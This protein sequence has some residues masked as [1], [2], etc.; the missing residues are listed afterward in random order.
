MK[1]QKTI[2][3]DPETARLAGSMPNFSR[4][5]RVALHARAMGDDIESERR[6]RRTWKRV[7]DHLLDHIRHETK[8]TDEEMQD[9]L[10]T[11]MASARNQEEFNVD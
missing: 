6:L 8:A 10:L 7:A 5:V 1:I 11:A 2:S 9:L 3:L 4:F